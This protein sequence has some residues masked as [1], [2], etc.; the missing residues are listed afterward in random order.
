MSDW[1]YKLEADPSLGPDD[2]KTWLNTRGGQ[3]WE[4]VASQNLNG[5][6]QFMFKRP[7]Y[8]QHAPAAT[9]LVG[10]TQTSSG[11]Y[12]ALRIHDFGHCKVG[13]IEALRITCNLSLSDAKALTDLG[14]PITAATDSSRH[15]LD[16][17]ADQL[18]RAGA[19]ISVEKRRG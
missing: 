3:G 12:Y 18:R 7:S 19:S 14:P 10:L 13:L 2:L 5:A 15:K 6:S 17:M 16:A 8:L 11:T 4:L 1:E 9:A